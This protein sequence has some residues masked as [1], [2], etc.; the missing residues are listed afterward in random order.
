MTSV[1]NMEALVKANAVCVVL[2]TKESVGPM[3]YWT[4]PN[5]EGPV[6]R[7][8]LPE[9]VDGRWCGPVLTTATEVL[10]HL[11]QTEEPCSVPVKLAQQLFNWSLPFAT[12][13]EAR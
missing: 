10:T 6:I 8:Y 7:T 2:R 4:K 11:A 5:N 9:E 12:L 1:S 13:P 3:V